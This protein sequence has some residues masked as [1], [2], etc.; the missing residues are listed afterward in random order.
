MSK[1]VPSSK[2]IFFDHWLVS[3]LRRDHLEKPTGLSNQPRGSRHLPWYHLAYF[4][5]LNGI[6]KKCAGALP[7]AALRAYLMGAPADRCN[8]GPKDESTR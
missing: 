4:R 5:G 6:Y 3:D 8:C 7:E 2:L 1:P